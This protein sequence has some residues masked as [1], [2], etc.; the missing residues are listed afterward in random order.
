M[1]DDPVSLTIAGRQVEDART[2][3]LQYA[4][5][6]PGTLRRYDLP[7]I[8][9]PNELTRD[10]IVRTR[11]IASRISEAQADRLA[12]LAHTAPWQDVP[13]NA[14]LRDADPQCTDG[15]Y[16]GALALYDHFRIG[17]GPGINVAKISKALHIKRPNLYPILDSHLLRAYR[18]AAKAA[19]A[20]YAETWG[21]NRQLYWAAIRLD[22]LNS[23]NAAALA[24][25]R[26]KLRADA[27]EHA[28]LL[29]PLTDLR[30]LDIMTWTP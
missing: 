30:L 19:G 25:V 21:P 26:A 9:K 13:T 14:D 11:V 22:L 4:T 5:Q 27:S 8:G 3:L 17:A 20:A 10:E 28:K 18:P 23:T 7:G 2:V 16:A 29:A 24:E 1:A 6:H 15:L 12:T